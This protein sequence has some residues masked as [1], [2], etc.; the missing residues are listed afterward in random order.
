[1]ATEDLKDLRVQKI[2]CP[3]FRSKR[4][5]IEKIEVAIVEE[6]DIKK[7]I[8]LIEK[9]LDELKDIIKCEYFKEGKIDCKICQDIIKLR[10]RNLVRKKNQCRKLPPPIIGEEN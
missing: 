9:L 7:R 8:F 5:Q 3:L 6:E 4:D 1:M 2:R 10:K